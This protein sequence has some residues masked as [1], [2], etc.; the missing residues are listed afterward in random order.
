MKVYF[1]ASVINTETLKVRINTEVLDLDDEFVETL[2]AQWYCM[3]GL[4]NVTLNH[5][6]RRFPAAIRRR[7]YYEPIRD[8][9]CE[10]YAGY[11]VRNV[12]TALNGKKTVHLT[13]RT[14]K[15]LPERV[16]S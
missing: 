3:F 14:T 10:K 2:Q 6:I 8:A 9:L 15:P 5:V 7:D 4:R 1:T 11:I 12:I 13:L 16:R